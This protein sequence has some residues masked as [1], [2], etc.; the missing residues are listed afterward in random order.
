MADGGERLWDYAFRLY[1]EPGVREA[2]L[3][4]QD[5]HGVDV[6]LLLWAAWLGGGADAATLRAGDMAVAPWRARAIRPARGLRRQLRAPVAGMEDA[7]RLAWR[8]AVK[9]L[10]V[11]AERAALERLARIGRRGGPPDL[12]PFATVFG[13]APD[14]PELAR[15]AAAARRL[16]GDAR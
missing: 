12:A 8:E 11:E 10:E 1:G 2:C 13:L 6:T 7:A 15:V 5:R 4:L 14:A 9:A 16:A 3:A